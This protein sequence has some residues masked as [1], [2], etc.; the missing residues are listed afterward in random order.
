GRTVNSVKWVVN[1][2]K[3]IGNRFN[4]AYYLLAFTSCLM[5]CNS[6]FTPK[7]T[8]YYAIPFPEKKYQTFDKPGYPYAFEYPV[9]ASVAKDSIFFG[10]TNENPWWININFPQFNGRIYISYKDIKKNN[11]DTLVK[12]AFT[13]TGK[14]TVKAYAI[15]DSVIHTKNNVEGIFFTVSG[16]VATANQFFLTDSTRHFLRGALY[17]DATPNAD[18]LGIVNKFLI[19]DVKYLINSFR[20]KNR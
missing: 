13:L 8:G 12:H 11:F 9:Y 6:P 3:G 15:N 2:V 19:E 16:D 7:P 5:S 20:W 1:R 10:E 4:I 17:F 14:H 18:S